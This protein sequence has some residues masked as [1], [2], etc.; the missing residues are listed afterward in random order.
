MRYDK[1]AAVEDSS[2]KEDQTHRPPHRFERLQEARR[3]TF[4]ISILFALRPTV[5]LILRPDAV[6]IQIQIQA[7]TA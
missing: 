7:H 1:T 6:P 4:P 2:R 5:Q 3:H